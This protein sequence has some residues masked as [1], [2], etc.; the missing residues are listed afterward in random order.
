MHPFLA[1]TRAGIN[2][3]YAAMLT[4]MRAAD[5]ARLPRS[6]AYFLAAPLIPFFLCWPAL[7]V[8]EVYRFWCAPDVMK[9]KALFAPIRWRL[10]VTLVRPAASAPPCG[11][12]NLPS[13]GRCAAASAPTSCTRSTA[14]TACGWW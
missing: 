13:S 9:M 4:A 14:S 7:G 8:T 5:L 6:A 12:H 11:V 3:Y 1:L 2:A 10:C